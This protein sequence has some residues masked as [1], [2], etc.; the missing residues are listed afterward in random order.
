M[1]AAAECVRHFISHLGEPL[2]HEG[3]ILSVCQAIFNRF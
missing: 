1:A 3:G 2:L